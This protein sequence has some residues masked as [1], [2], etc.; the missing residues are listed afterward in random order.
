MQIDITEPVICLDNFLTPE[1]CERIILNAG[2]VGYK[3]RAKPQEGRKTQEVF[4]EDKKIETEI[5]EKLRSLLDESLE[6]ELSSPLELFKYLEGDYVG[7]HTDAFI[8]LPDGSFSN[9]T[10]LIYLNDGFKNG[11]T[12]F[13]D[14]DL[15]IEPRV[16]TALIFD[17][18]TLHHEGKK[19]DQGIKYI[20]RIC[21]RVS[22]TVEIDN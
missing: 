13:N 3:Y 9:K 18:S 4:L 16:G 20:L 1:T 5:R 6:L 7:K 21:I 19:V 2:E 17:Q 15:N 12:Y 22:Q 14:F 8:K 10:F 11:G